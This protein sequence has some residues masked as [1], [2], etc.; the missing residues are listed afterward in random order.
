M[1]DVK[2]TEV[3][4]HIPTSV[5]AHIAA[6]RAHSSTARSISTLP[7]ADECIEA[8]SFVYDQL[9]AAKIVAMEVFGSDKPEIVF[10]VFDRIGDYPNNVP[11]TAADE[12][13]GDFQ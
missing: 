13:E 2:E 4:N 6:L 10:Q 8:T 12:D 11:I 7:P 9:R 5:D 3:Q 1:T